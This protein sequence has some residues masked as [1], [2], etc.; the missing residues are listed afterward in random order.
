MA[1]TKDKKK[2]RRRRRVRAPPQQNVRASNLA[3]ATPTNILL[4]QQALGR[5]IKNVSTAGL[6]YSQP[7]YDEYVRNINQRSI[8]QRYN[9]PDVNETLGVRARQLVRD[10]VRPHGHAPPRERSQRVGTEPASGEPP[11]ERPQR[12]EVSEL[13]E[14]EG[15]VRDR[16]VFE[17]VD[18]RVQEARERG[19]IQ[20]IDA[21]PKVREAEER[22]DIQSIDVSPIKQERDIE[23]QEDLG[24]VADRAVKGLEGIDEQLAAL[25]GDVGGMEANLSIPEVSAIAGPP[26]PQS[27]PGDDLASILEAEEQYATPEAQIRRPDPE[28]YNYNGEKFLYDPNDEAKSDD[29]PIPGSPTPSYLADYDTDTDA[30]LEYNYDETPSTSAEYTSVTPSTSEEYTSV[31]PTLLDKIQEQIGG[32]ILPPLQYEKTAAELGLEKTETRY[33][34]LAAQVDPSNIIN[35]PENQV[36]TL[37]SRVNPTEGTPATDLFEQLQFLRTATKDQ[38]RDLMVDM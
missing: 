37:R 2:K 23:L 36:R 24:Q 14:E 30:Q 12:T 22:G 21:S 33:P 15:H 3:R 29:T 11:R 16:N 4:E 28:E 19:D 1:S 25:Q 9:R 6:E 26:Q 32:E 31:T 17:R 18:A 34:R 27:A 7:V 38:I 35:T 13:S 5:L 10:L 8:A 20:S